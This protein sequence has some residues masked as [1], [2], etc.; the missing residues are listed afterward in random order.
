[1]R[2]VGLKVISCG[3][4][5]GLGVRLARVGWLLSLIFDAL[6]E[7]SEAQVGNLRYSRPGGLRYN[8]GG[9]IRRAGEFNIWGCA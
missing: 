6:G 9:L 3:E 5:W 2:G 8:C 1:M 7:A 4:V